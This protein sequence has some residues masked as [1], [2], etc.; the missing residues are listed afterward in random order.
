MIFSESQNILLVSL[1]WWCSIMS[2]SVMQNILLLLLLLSS[3]SRSQQGLIGSKYDSFYHIFWIVDSLATKL[4]LMVHHLMPECPV[5]KVG[6]LHSASRSQQR[7]KMLM[8]VQIVSAKP[9]SI[10]FPNLVLWCIIMHE[11]IR[12][13][14]G[15][16]FWTAYP[17][18]TK[19]GSIVH[20]HKPECFMEKL[21]CC[22][23]GQGHSKISNCQW[24]LVQMISSEM[25]NLLLPNLEPDCLSKRLV[26]CLPGQGHSYR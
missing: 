12:T 9:P 2:Q 1:V 4:G 23:Q 5:N 15:D 26:G 22:V 3:R 16:V 10:L 24:M 25:L 17:F 18:A 21:D 7:V 8:F 19:L 6:L 20:Y 11:L 13:K 14:Y